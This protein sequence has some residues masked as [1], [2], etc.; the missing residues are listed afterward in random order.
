MKKLLFLFAICCFQAQAQFSED[1]AL[2]QTI[3][4]SAGTANGFDLNANYIRKE[5]YTFKLGFSAFYKEAEQKPDDFSVGLIEAFFLGLTSPIDVMTNYQ[6][7][8]GRLFKLNPKG[9]IRLN[10][11]AGLAYSKF[12]TAVN[13]IP[14]NGGLIDRNYTH[15]YRKSS[16]ISFLLNPKIEFPLGRFYGLALSP[17]MILSDNHSYFGIGIEQ[18]VGLLRKR[19]KLPAD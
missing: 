5:R 3:A 8:F 16:A 13:F 15:R 9:T 11:S 12:S 1:N 17:L 14:S 4:I 10:L 7:Q 2:Y 19:D 18:M 6:A